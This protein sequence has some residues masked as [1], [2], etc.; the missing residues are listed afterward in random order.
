MNVSI[1]HLSDT[2]LGY[3][4]YDAISAGGTN[5][6]GEDVVR[7]FRSA[8]SQIC[9]W[10]P[11]LV[12]HSG[13]VADRPRVNVRYLLEIQRGIDQLRRRPD[14][15]IRPVVIIAGNHD[16][17]RNLQDVCY[18]ELWRSLEGVHIVTRGYEQ[19]DVAGVVV[20][21]LPHDSL[22]SVNLERVRP[23]DGRVNV[24]TTHGVAEGSDLFLRA[25]GREFPVPGS[26]LGR[27]WDYVALG[28]WHRQG[29]VDLGGT[30]GGRI[31]YAGSIETFGF[32]D[33]YNDEGV[34]RGW[35]QVTI[36]GHDVEIVP[37]VVQNR[38]MIR[39][40]DLDASGLTPDQIVGG[41]VARVQAANTRR[42]V[43]GQRVLNVPRDVWNLSDV[44]AVRRAASDALFYRLWVRG[45]K[46]DA[47]SGVERK[48]IGDV[49]ELVKAVVDADVEEAL[50]DQVWAAA[51]GLLVE[52]RDAS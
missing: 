18:L 12:I 45:P 25:V 38:R 20:H 3:E 9:A 10:D 28:H 36:T 50:R 29:P 49:D 24:L 52:V 35:L 21:A 14:G 26:M 32:G 6:R 19:V 46:G 40:P 44:A 41:L 7:A 2:H 39:L 47:A 13:D 31:W 43:V 42:A 11:D 51:Q 1:A 33:L 48:S 5:Q 16:Q 15:S 8:V 22:R 17:S 27:G 4:M 34:E 30:A 23:V 37:Q